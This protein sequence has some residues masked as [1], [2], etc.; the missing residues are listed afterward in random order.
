MCIRDRY[1]A[2]YE[3]HPA[4]EMISKLGLDYLLKIDLRKFRWSKK[5]IDTVSYTHLT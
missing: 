3:K 1:L 4:V 2:M 5:G